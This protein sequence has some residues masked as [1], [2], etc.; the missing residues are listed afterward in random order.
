M[1][2][3]TQML[4]I[5]R[6]DVSG[7]A[8]IALLH[9]HLREMHEISPPESVHAL[10]VAELRAPD[11]TFWTV[12]VGEELAGCG[13]LKELTPE[14]GE[15]KSMRTVRSF[16]RRG[17]G[18]AMV[19]H[20]V[21]EARGRGYRMLSLETGSQEHFVPAQNLYASFGFEECGCFADYADDPNSVFMTLSLVPAST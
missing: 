5:T 10:D 9:E 8:I 17:V 15:I 21:E 3:S 11:I 12:W 18:S 19:Q 14:H 1:V 20:I 2:P 7:E 13:A 4:R 16:R 6:D